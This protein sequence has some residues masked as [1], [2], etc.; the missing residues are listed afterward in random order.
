MG[1]VSFADVI[2]NAKRAS[3]AAAPLAAWVTSN[4][5]YAAI[6]EKIEPLETEQAQLQR[7]SFNVF[8]T[9]T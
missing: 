4:V 5:K 8:T 9:L 7:Y 1:L 3:E 6:I 2:Q